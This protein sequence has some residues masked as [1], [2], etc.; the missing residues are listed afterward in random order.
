MRSSL[1]SAPFQVY[2]FILYE[3]SSVARFK[4]DDTLEVAKAALWLSWS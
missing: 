2:R 3:Y 4:Y 1:Q